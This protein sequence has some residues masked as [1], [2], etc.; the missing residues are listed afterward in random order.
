MH[1]KTKFAVLGGDARQISVAA[2][3]LK[4][5]KSVT[6]FALPKEKEIQQATHVEDWREAISGAEAVLLPLP[7][8]PDGI[9]VNL[10]LAAAQSAPRLLEIFE[11]VGGGVPV[12]GGKFS[13]AV[14]AMAEQKGVLL[15]DYCRSEEFQLQ[16]AVPTAEGAIS[17]LMNTLPCTIKGLEVAV[18]GYGRVARALCKLLVAMGAEVTVAARKSAALQEAALA[19]C[20]TLRLEGERS[21]I[22]LAK[23]KRVVLNTVPYWLFTE[24]VLRGLSKDVLLVDLASA[25]GGVDAQAASALGIPVIF[26]L[27]LP[28]KYAPVS[29]GHIIAKTVLSALQ[30]EGL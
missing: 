13:P 5:G 18:T 2:Y 26:A 25:P 9:H 28:G 1:T 27:S 10:P 23:G 14:K 24:E 15:Y 29:A 4:A 17:V 6:V 20:R 30:E 8:S 22:A 3:L 11:R 19:G 21:V 16:N 12:F 7:A